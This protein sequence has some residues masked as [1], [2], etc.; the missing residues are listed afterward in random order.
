MYGSFSLFGQ[1]GGGLFRS[2]GRFG[3]SSSGFSGG[4]FSSGS[5]SSSG[6]CGS[7]LG[8]CGFGSGGLSGFCVLCRS[9][10]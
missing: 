2:S 1:G 4:S 3:G 8:C 10:Q 9:G 5:F 6:F 7:G